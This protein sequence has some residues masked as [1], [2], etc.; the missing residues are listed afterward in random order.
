MTTSSKTCSSA[1]TSWTKDYR[2]LIGDCAFPEER[3][4]ARLD[5]PRLDI[6]RHVYP[7]VRDNLWEFI[8]LLKN[9]DVSA[10]FGHYDLD[11]IMVIR[12][13]F[14]PG[15]QAMCRKFGLPQ[16]KFPSVCNREL[17]EAHTMGKGSIASR[18]LFTLVGAIWKQMVSRQIVSLPLWPVAPAD[19][20]AQGGVTTLFGRG[21]LTR[22]KA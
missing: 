2:D 18:D 15:N 5:A 10:N 1:W 16:D 21:L 22:A 14:D 20:S 17:L 11:D 9:V 13:M 8:E 6:I 12:M 19:D 3:I 4:H 7:M